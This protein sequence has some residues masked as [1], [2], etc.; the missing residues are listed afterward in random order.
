MTEIIKCSKCGRVVSKTFSSQVDCRKCIWSKPKHLLPKPCLN[1]GNDFK[2][3]KH[4]RKYCSKKCFSEFQVNNPELYKDSRKRGGIIRSKKLTVLQPIQCGYCKDL[5][6]PRD[7]HK[8]YCSEKCFHLSSR[9]FS[10]KNCKGCNVLFRP[11]CSRGLYCNKLCFNEFQ[12][13]NPEPH[14]EAG[15]KS[16]EIQNLRSKNEIYFYEL[17]K[18]E[19]SDALPNKRMFNGWDADVV[20]PKHKVAVAWNGVWHYRGVT[21]GR[22]LIKTQKR[23]NLKKKEINKCGYLLYTVKDMGSEDKSFVHNE[24]NL[25]KQ[26]INLI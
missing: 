24:F 21:Y 7:S 12:R 15:R 18:Q 10:E 9:T 19:W 3:K 25:F 26:Y 5:F 23:D 17:C 8:K 16:A 2:P 20:L 22:S 1:C 14:V 6:K 4:E 11:Q 13:K